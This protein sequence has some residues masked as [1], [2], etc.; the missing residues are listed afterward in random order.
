MCWNENELLIDPS[1]L[2][3]Q[4]P[5]AGSGRGGRTDPS[6]TNECPDRNQVSRIIELRSNQTRTKAPDSE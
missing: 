3:L 2:C 1:Q 4:S 6:W 5:T